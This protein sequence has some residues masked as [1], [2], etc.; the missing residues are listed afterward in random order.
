MDLTPISSVPG[1]AAAIRLTHRHRLPASAAGKLTADS[2]VE[3]YRISTGDWQEEVDSAVHVIGTIADRLRR[4]AT[5]YGQWGV[6][7]RNAFFDMQPT[8]ASLLLRLSER[9]STVHAIFYADLLLPSFQ[10]VEQYWVEEFFPA[11]HSAYPFYQQ[12]DRRSSYNVHFLEIAQPKMQAYW[13]R[14]IQVVTATQTV[15]RSDPSFL[16]AAGGGEERDRWRHAWAMEPAPGLASD[17]LPDLATL[18]TLTLSVTFPLPVHRQT[19]RMRRLRRTWR[20][21]RSRRHRGR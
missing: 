6:F 13:K 9:V 21:W 16:A 4:L 10:R 18:P 17:L 8:Q 11:F 1:M 5:A 7:D 3:T 15:L 14:L 20:Q 19:G 2:L 12:P